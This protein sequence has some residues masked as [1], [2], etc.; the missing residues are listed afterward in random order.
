MGT[1]MPSP[2]HRTGLTH[3][4]EDAVIPAW[5]RALTLGDR[6]AINPAG[7]RADLWGHVPAAGGD[8]VACVPRPPWGQI[9][10]SLGGITAVYFRTGYTAVW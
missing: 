1:G 2:Q 7:S 8:H 3:R 9:R 6:D 4:D 5:S 10:A